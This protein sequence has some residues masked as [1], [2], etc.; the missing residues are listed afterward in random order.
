MIRRAFFPI[1]LASLFVTCIRAQAPAPSPAASV[2]NT[3]SSPAMDPA[4]SARMENVEI[5]RDRVHITLLDGTIQFA[6]PANGV[7]F[8]ATFHGKGRVQVDPPNPI[9]A[10]QLRLFTKQ[11][12]LDMPFTDGTFSFTDGLFDEV[13]K[14]VQWQPS[15]GA[16][17]DLY[18][19]RQKAREDL[20]EAAVPRL[21]QG[22]LSA[23]GA[24]TAYFLADLKVAG[25]DWVEFHYDALDP[26][27]IKVGRW[28]DVGPLKLDDTW[29]HFPAHNQS[30][31]DALKDPL[32][33]EDF[34][35]RA[36]NINA[37][38]T[39]GAELSANTKMTL[40]PRLAGQSVLIFDF[41]FESSRRV[42]QVRARN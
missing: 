1:V 36:Y 10:Q 15:G 18:A 14:Q 21:L 17:D 33:K 27:E 25:K 2:W 26:E 6:Q 16:S 35:I 23:D 22:V 24:R 30:S 4:K 11:D 32:A 28:V 7:V 38:V 31:A 5:V 34:V 37:S 3:L 40:A 12:K 9:E 13:A 39:S 29:M 41:R 42:G 8:G 19:N 20:G